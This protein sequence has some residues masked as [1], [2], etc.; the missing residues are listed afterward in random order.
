MQKTKTQAFKKWFQGSVVTVDGTP[1]SEP[2][3][4][5]HG[6]YNVFDA[7]QYGDIGYHFGN[8]DQAKDRTRPM[9]DTE[10][11]CDPQIMP[12]YLSL[13][14]PYNIVSDLGDWSDMDMLKEYLAEGNEGPFTDAEFSKLKGPQDVKNALM[15]K[16]F[17]GFVYENAFEKSEGGNQ[18]SYI[19]FKATQ[20][21]SIYNNGAFDVD[22]PSIMDSVG[23]VVNHLCAEPDEQEIRGPGM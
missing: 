8:K 6:T 12:V 17:D 11:P 5:Y 10:Y 9:G 14:N 16:G 1:G 20:I 19:A 7:F 4:V 2:L 23:P 15:A 3:I 13:Q 22:N 21:K 18:L